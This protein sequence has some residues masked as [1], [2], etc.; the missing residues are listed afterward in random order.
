ML[1]KHFGGD[2][3]QLALITSLAQV[4]WRYWDQGFYIG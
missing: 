2:E 1:K 3:E 4:I